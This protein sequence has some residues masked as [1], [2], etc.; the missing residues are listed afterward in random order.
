MSRRVY[1]ESYSH[2]PHPP[3]VATLETCVTVG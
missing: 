1:S 2:L 3:Q